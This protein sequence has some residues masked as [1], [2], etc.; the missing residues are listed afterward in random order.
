MRWRGR[1]RVYEQTI[2]ARRPLAERDDKVQEEEG[3][4]T[5]IE[6]RKTRQDKTKDQV[7]KS[8]NASLS[9]KPPREWEWGEWGN[10]AVTWFTINNKWQR[11]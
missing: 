2:P 4:M 6:L 8:E 7:E 9:L 11:H 1:W 10:V 5:R 3:R